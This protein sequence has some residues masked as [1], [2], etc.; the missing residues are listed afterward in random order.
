MLLSDDRQ[1]I[2]SNTAA[3]R[4]PRFTR[5]AANDPYFRAAINAA[6]TRTYR[7]AVSARLSTSER[8]DLYQEILL[9]LLER[10]AQ[11]N[12]EKGSP[13]TFTGFVSE[14]RTAEFLKAR[15]TDRERIPFASGEDVDT[16]EIVNISRARQGMNETQDAAN[17][18]DAAPIGS[19]EAHYR[20][21]W[22]DG[23]DDLFSNSNTL[24]DLETAMAHMSEEQAEFLDLLASHQDLPTASKAC[25]MSSATFYRRVAE[26]Q[27]HLRMFGIRTAA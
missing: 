21:Q 11:F 27:M 1:K 6:K 4:S 15:K 22:F 8:E 23:D 20:S 14:H 7:A 24:H 2:T 26:L 9:D 3:M 10:E 25:G 17:D 5:D 18:A 19:S 12:P 16:L 13:G